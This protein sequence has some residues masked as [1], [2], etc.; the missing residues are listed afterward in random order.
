MIHSGSRHL[1]KEVTEYYLKEGQ[2]ILKEKGEEVPYPLTYLEGELLE[3]YIQDVQSVTRYASLNRAIIVSEILKGMKW[4]EK[5]YQECIH[6]YIDLGEETLKYLGAPVLRKG[7]ISAKRNE[8][9]IIPINMKE[10][11]IL[12]TGL[13][14]MDWNLSAP[15][16]AGRILKREDVANQ[17]TVSSF[18]EEMKGIYTSCIG[19]ETLDEAPFAYRKMEDMLEAVKDTVKINEVIHPVYNF[20]AK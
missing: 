4:K 7:A 2:K 11:V 17:Y 12:G 9:V 16:G 10:G 14:N 20:K 13:G 15:H 8:D 3:Q 1:G 5:N 6:N 18:K 19:K